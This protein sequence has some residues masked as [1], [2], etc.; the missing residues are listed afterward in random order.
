M[1]D[2]ARAFLSERRFAVLATINGDG[3][4]QQSTMWYDLRGDRIMMNTL[5]GRLKERNLKR[6]PRISMCVEDEY[7]YV[8]IKGVVELDYDRDRS[9]ADIKALAVRYEGEE[10]G[11]RMARNT[12]RPQDRVT[13]YITIEKIDIHTSSVKR[14]VVKR[15]V[16]KRDA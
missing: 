8:A 3:T 1:D 7:D 9:Q 16:V 5:V 4:P 10:G 2:N 13:M 15:D 14:D 11:E 6:D 12:F